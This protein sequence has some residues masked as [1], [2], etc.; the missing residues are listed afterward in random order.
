MSAAKELT[1]DLH[2]VTDYFA[3]A[4]LTNRRNCLNC[5]FEAV[6]RMSRPSGDQLESL[7]VVIS[8]NFTF[9]HFR[10]SHNK[11]IHRAIMRALSS[12]TF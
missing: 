3:V 2:A 12:G 7:V 4:V 6:E 9:R 5:T 1:A 11:R 8:A 10:T